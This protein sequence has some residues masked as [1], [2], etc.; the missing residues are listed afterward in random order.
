MS[1][2][3]PSVNQKMSR[4]K[5]EDHVDM[6]QGTT[7]LPIQMAG[8]GMLS[9]FSRNR[10]ARIQVLVKDGIVAVAVSPSDKMQELPDEWKDAEIVYDRRGKRL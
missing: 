1:Q 7:L 10:Q 9:Q 8:E 2:A 6:T 4:K 5:I 3:F